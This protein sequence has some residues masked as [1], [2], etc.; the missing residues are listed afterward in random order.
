MAG[1]LNA[2]FD[3]EVPPM[4]VQAQLNVALEPVGDQVTHQQVADAALLVHTTLGKRARGE[5]T[6]E[7]VYQ[8]CQYHKQ[9]ESR[10]PNAM[11]GAP[12]WATAL[13]NLMNQKIAAMNQDI[14]AMTAM[15]NQN[16]A[17]MNARL[18]RIDQRLDLAL[19]PEHIG[20][21]RFSSEPLQCA[22]D[23]AAIEPS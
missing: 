10:S 12:A 8:A 9:V 1:L 22:H 7:Q 21:D 13:M 15:I 14:T 6:S 19:T 2:P 11:E 20:P 4:V 18:D 3:I 23:S 17:E 16:N 5:C